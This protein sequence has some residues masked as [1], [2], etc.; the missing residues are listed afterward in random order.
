MQIADL[1]LIRYDEAVAL[2]QR[3]YEAVNQ[4]CD[5]T[6]YLA[7]H[8]SVITLGRHGGMENLRARQE[9]LRGRQIELIQSSRGGNITCH[10]PGQLVAYPVFRLKSDSDAVHRLFFNLE[11]MVLRTLDDFS[12]AGKRCHGKPGVWV[13]DKKI[14]SIGVAITHGIVRHGLSLN[15]GPDISLFSLID[16]CGMRGVAPTSMSLEAG[17]EILMEEVKREFV[18]HAKELFADTFMA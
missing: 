8:W 17:R 7:E 5:G 12:I 16:L 4:G 6:F 9:D 3:S 11:E 1:G 18:K 2:Q 15:V 10:F 13:H 14:C